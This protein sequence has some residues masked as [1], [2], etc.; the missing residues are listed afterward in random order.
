MRKSN[1]FFKKA[2]RYVEQ[3]N[4]EKAKKIYIEIIEAN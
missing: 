3:A 4:Y 1:K 2:E